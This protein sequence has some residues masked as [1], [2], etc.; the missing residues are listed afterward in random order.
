MRKKSEILKE[1]FDAGTEPE[2]LPR[3]QYDA[4]QLKKDVRA[5]RTPEGFDLRPITRTAR[6]Q[7]LL[8]EQTK[9]RLENAAAEL[10]ISQNEAINRAVRVWLKLYEETKDHE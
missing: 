7:L 8:T 6:M 3:R 10:G 4:E 2:K 1:V 5:M 9:A